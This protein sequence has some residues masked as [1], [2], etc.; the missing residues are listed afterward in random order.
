MPLA[1][2]MAVPSG[3]NKLPTTPPIA[4]FPKENFVF[5]EIGTTFVL[6][7]KNVRAV[8]LFCHCSS[9]IDYSKSGSS[10]MIADIVKLT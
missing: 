6:P 5:V 1:T 4:A 10:V 9:P 8:H 2:P 3:L 7:Q